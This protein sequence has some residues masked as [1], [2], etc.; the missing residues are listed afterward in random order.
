MKLS[1]VLLLSAVIMILLAFGSIW[2]ITN[3]ISIIKVVLPLAILA[4]FVSG[5]MLGYKLAR[6]R[7]CQAH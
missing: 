6:A 5:C 1:N 4:A 7:F 3:I 2:V